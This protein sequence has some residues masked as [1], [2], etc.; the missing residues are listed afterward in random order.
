[1]IIAENRAVVCPGCGKIIDVANNFCPYCRFE[2]RKMHAPQI[3]KTES[4][5]KTGTTIKKTAE[6]V[7]KDED[8]RKECKESRKAQQT[9][10]EDKVPKS[11]SSPSAP[12]ANDFPKEFTEDTFIMF[13]EKFEYI[14]KYTNK[15]QEEIFKQLKKDYR[16][17]RKDK[18]IIRDTEDDWSFMTSFHDNGAIGKAPIYIGIRKDKVEENKWFV[19]FVGIKAKNIHKIMRQD[20]YAPDGWGNSFKTLAEMALPENWGRKYKILDSYLS[21][22]YYG[23]TIQKN[24]IFHAIEGTENIS[25]FD[26]GLVNNMYKPIYACL[27]NTKGK[28]TVSGKRVKRNFKYELMGF[29]LAGQGS[30]NNT[31]GKMITSCFS[32]LPTKVNFIEGL[33]LSSLI[34]DTNKEVILDAEHIIID[35]IAR[36]P[37]YFLI[38]NSKYGEDE[39]ISLINEAYETNEFEALKEYI[40][41]K[42]EIKRRL[43]GVIEDAKDMAINRCTWNYKTAIPI[44]YPAMNEISLILPLALNPYADEEAQKADVALVVSKQPSGNY[45]GETILTLNMAYKDSRQIT[46]PDSDWLDVNH[47][48][49]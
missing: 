32:E 18:R 49:I 7:R 20:I 6:V 30:R 39:F 3:D 19:S 42:S 13:P 36:L 28:S 25:I 5:K 33:D 16:D 15:S 11:E 10:Q 48:N 21:Y 4:K 26:T 40:N 34:L 35:N 24:K 43:A 38:N 14:K 29:A 22:T 41:N 47:I 23:A 17:A 1:M 45:Q 31:L 9:S 27:A 46:R 2:L 12:S 44:Y 8:R 37:K